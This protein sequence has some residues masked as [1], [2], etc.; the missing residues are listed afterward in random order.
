MTGL[1]RSTPLSRIEGSTLWGL[2]SE[3][4]SVGI[5]AGWDLILLYLSPQWDWLVRS[6]PWPRIEELSSDED[7]VGIIACWD[8]ILLYLS[9]RWDRTCMKYS[10]AQGGNTNF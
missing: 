2:S 5:F 9:P 3:E 10:M 7:S 6:S 4:D 8:L 1:V